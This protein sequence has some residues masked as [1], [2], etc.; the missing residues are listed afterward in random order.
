MRPFIKY[1][2]LVQLWPVNQYVSRCGRSMKEIG[3]GDAAFRNDARG[4][5]VG[6]FYCVRLV[7]KAK[8]EFRNL[9]L[10]QA[11]HHKPHTH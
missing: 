6:A 4:E 11:V 1:D 3:G 9:G 2:L 8:D 5:T 7:Q 10:G